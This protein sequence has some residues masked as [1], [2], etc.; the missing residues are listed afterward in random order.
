MQILLR[1]FKSLYLLMYYTRFLLPS[2]NQTRRTKKCNHS[3]GIYE[4]I[5][6][7]IR[8]FYITIS[9]NKNVYVS[10][11]EVI[12]R[13][14]YYVTKSL[15]FVRTDRFLCLVLWLCREYAWY[16]YMRH[17]WGFPLYRP[18]LLG[19][20]TSSRGPMGIPTLHPLDGK[21]SLSNA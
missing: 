14:Y 20:S 8:L 2:L 16:D 12:I 1:C 6:S 15:C 18:E 3:K 21:R 13:I 19:I 17:F 11:M 7:K 10:Y 9:W 5:D 4:G